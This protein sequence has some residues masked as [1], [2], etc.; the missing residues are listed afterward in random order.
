VPRELIL[1]RSEVDPHADHHEPENSR[2]DLP[3]GEDPSDFP[4]FPH[5]VVGPLRSDRGITGCLHELRRSE[6]PQERRRDDM[7]LW[8]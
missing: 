1:T 7:A 5:E 8:A 4:I 2:G 3:F 6:Q